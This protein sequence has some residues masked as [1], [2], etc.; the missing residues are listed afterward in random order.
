MQITREQLDRLIEDKDWAA[1]EQADVS[2]VTDMSGLFKH[3]NG[4]ENLD[5]SG[6]DTKKCHKYESYVLR[7]RIQP[8][9]GLF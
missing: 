8:S 4:I 6:W 7:F 1:V 3:I 9:V 2:E 5:L